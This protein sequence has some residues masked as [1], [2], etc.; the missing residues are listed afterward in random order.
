MTA[1]LDPGGKTRL[2]PHFAPDAMIVPLKADSHA[3]E[4]RDAVEAALDGHAV[5]FV[6]I[7]GDHSYE[8]VKRDF[9]SYVSLVADDGIVGLHDIDNP[10]T[11]IS[12]FWAELG[13]CYRT[14]IVGDG[15]YKNGGLCTS[16]TESGHPLQ[17]HPPGP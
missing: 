6:Y 9:E 5:D 4:T 17:P 7:D 2:F 12:R 3:E 15:D 10:N 1:D 13:E 8:G 16:T 11:G 14:E